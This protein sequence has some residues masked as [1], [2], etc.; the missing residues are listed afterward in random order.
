MDEDSDGEDLPEYLQRKKKPEKERA[1]VMRVADIQG[2]EDA[3]GVQFDEGGVAIEPFN[4][5]EELQLGDMDESG[6][7]TL[8]KDAHTAN[9]PWLSSITGDDIRKAQAAQ[10]ARQ[11]REAATAAA[12]KDEPDVDV[13]TLLRQL[14]NALKPHESPAAAL[15]RFGASRPSPAQRWSKKAQAATA[16]AA[17]TEEEKALFDTVTRCAD[18]LMARG[19]TDIYAE[20]RE[21]IERH[22]AQAVR[23]AASIMWEYK[24]SADT[25]EVFGPFTSQQMMQWREGVRLARLYRT[26]RR[27]TH[28]SSARRICSTTRSSCAGAP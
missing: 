9:D 7:Y 1:R 20:P 12:A 3:S 11:Q 23:D 13:G 17:P 2:Q 26:I 4:M 10:A 18:Q 8:K 25:D 5:R 15:R 6:T 27:N 21:M 14:V 22:L 16:A 24:W 28:A 19:M